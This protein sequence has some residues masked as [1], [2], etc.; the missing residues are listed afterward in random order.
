MK[1]YQ[2]FIDGEWRDAGNGASSPPINPATEENWATF[3]DATAEDVDAIRDYT[4]TKG[5][6]VDLSGAVADPFVMR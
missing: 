5:I 1:R 3:A 4:D 6:F 2:M